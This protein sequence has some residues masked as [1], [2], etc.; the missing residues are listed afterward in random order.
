M[1]IKKSPFLVPVL[2]IAGLFACVKALPDAK[3][4]VA[5]LKNSAPI[6]ERSFVCGE[7][8]DPLSYSAFTSATPTASKMY[9]IEPYDQLTVTLWSV[10]TPGS[11]TL[12]QTCASRT[13][14]CYTV[15][16]VTDPAAMD[17]ALT[18]GVQWS[19]PTG[20]KFVRIIPA[21][22]SGTLKGCVGFKRAGVA[23]L[24]PNPVSTLTPTPTVTPTATITPT[25]TSTPTTT[26]TATRT[27]TRTTTPTRTSTPTPTI[28]P[29]AT[30]TR[31]VT[32]TP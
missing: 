32:P 11:S 28:T 3:A 29:T 27:A 20:A 15:A 4:D 10:G 19:A 2:V 14:P 7:G 21:V 18:G 31:T 1:T 16:T 12:L 9:L 24:D 30:N 6:D 17:A 23:A 13:G 5:I 26:P 25:R 8:T 22:S